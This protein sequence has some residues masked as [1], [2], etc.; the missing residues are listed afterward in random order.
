[1][2]CR[3]MFKT[4]VFTWVYQVARA[5]GIFLSEA[6]VVDDVTRRS[7]VEDVKSASRTATS[8]ATEREKNVWKKLGGNTMG[9]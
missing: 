4:T 8:E 5:R 2:T 3:I 7:F 1:M 9:I 6:L